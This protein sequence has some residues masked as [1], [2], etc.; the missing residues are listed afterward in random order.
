MA[1]G[2]PTTP[3]PGG[4]RGPDGKVAIIAGCHPL[5]TSP[6]WAPASAGVVRSSG[7]VLRDNSEP[8][9]HDLPL[10]R[11]A[12]DPRMRLAQVRRVD[13]PEILRQRTDRKSTRLN[14]SHGY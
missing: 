12:L 1:I 7:F 2:K 13:P 9:K 3:H 10:R 5:A 4:G 8:L 14:S 11:V 6:N